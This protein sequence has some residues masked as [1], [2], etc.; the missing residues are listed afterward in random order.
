MSYVES[1]YVETG[2]I[3]GDGFLVPDIANAKLKFFISKGVLPEADEINQ[4]KN[5]LSK[6]EI[7]VFFIPTAR[8]FLLV[9]NKGFVEFITNALDMKIVENELKSSPTFIYFINSLIDSKLDLDYIS[10]KML[11]YEAFLDS[12]VSA[13]VNRLNVKVNMV[14]P[15]GTILASPTVTRDGTTF[16]FDVP[17]ELSGIEYGVS[18]EITGA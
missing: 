9:N 15:N 10:N 2:Y 17:P 12:L 18:I 4:V 1:G 3:E 8:K 13:I 16:A 14:A 5:S 7:G 6:D 11:S